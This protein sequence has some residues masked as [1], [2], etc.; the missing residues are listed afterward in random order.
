MVLMD[1]LNYVDVLN[2]EILYNNNTFRFSLLMFVL[3]TLKHKSYK[4]AFF[5]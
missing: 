4:K 1:I 5:S 2:G 3:Y